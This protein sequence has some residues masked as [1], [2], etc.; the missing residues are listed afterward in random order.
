[1]KINIHTLINY[2]ADMQ[3][4]I[5]TMSGDKITGLKP[6]MNDNAMKYD[7]DLRLRAAVVVSGRSHCPDC[8][9]E[10]GQEISHINFDHPVGNYPRMIAKL[11]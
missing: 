4:Q 2:K 7:L 11:N 5:F 6:D 1:M 8:S 10:F 9:R 3:G